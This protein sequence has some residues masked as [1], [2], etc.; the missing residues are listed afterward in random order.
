VDSE[1]VLRGFCV[2]HFVYRIRDDGAAAERMLAEWE[3]RQQSAK[4][5]PG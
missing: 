1:V 2:S 3:R 4:R 5:S